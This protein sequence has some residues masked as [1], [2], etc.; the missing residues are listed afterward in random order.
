MSTHLYFQ[1]EVSGSR[2]W[3]HFG[4]LMLSADYL[5][6]ALLAGVRADD[7]GLPA[8]E[9][10]VPKGLPEHWAEPTLREDSLVVDDEAANLEVPDTC[11]RADAEAWV[12]RGDAWFLE[13]RNR[14][15]HPD[16]SGHSWVSVSELRAIREAYAAR[17]GRDVVAVDAALALL[18]A[19]ETGGNECRA[20]FW[21][22]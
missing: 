22:G 14:V 2:G 3:W 18:A 19:W 17:N 13:D 4:R 8:A 6:F 21:F 15:T 20:V 1:V 10:G 5:L 16:A 11:T 7:V 9:R 12:S